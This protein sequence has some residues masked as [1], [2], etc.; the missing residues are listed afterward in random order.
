MFTVD[1]PASPTISA[2]EDVPFEK[3]G[4][5]VKIESDS[6]EGTIRYTTD[7][8][9]VTKNSRTYAGEFCIND[10]TTVRAKVFED[11]RFDSEESCMTFTR[12]W[13]TVATPLIEPNGAA[14]ANVS[15]TIS[16]SC[17]TVDATVLYTTDGRWYSS[18]HSRKHTV[19][20]Q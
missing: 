12:Q 15:Q 20:H 16:L 8:S 3:R 14:Y 6:D 7:G 4:F 18:D 5:R 1:Q 13:E 10:T 19:V 9:E 2:V 11:G 17:M